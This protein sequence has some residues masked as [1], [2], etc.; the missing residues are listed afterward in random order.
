MFPS[1]A[2]LIET[3]DDTHAV[4]LACSQP[5]GNAWI[6]RS[7]DGGATFTTVR[8]LGSFKGSVWT[9]R[10][11]SSHRLYVVDD[12]PLLI[13][14]HPGHGG[15]LAPAR[16]DRPVAEDDQ[17]LDPLQVLRREGADVEAET[18][19]VGSEAAS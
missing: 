19:G 6:V 1:V 12:G 5:G 3:S 16:P 8:A 13:R 18:A 14:D 2:T 9:P 10:D 7:L 15:L 4:F 11:G 17:E